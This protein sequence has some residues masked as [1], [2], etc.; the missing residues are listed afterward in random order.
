MAA[1]RAWGSCVSATGTDLDGF[2]YREKVTPFLAVA[3]AARDA[4]LCSPLQLLQGLHGKGERNVLPDVRLSQP[5]FWLTRNK[6]NEVLEKAEV[7]QNLS[8]CLDCV[9]VGNLLLL[10]MGGFWRQR[11]R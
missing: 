11:G 8:S 7:S 2:I 10:C 1:G 6:G 9:L 5:F 3:L 4:R